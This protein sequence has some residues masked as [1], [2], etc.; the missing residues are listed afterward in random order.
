M[1]MT[2][3][4][5]LGV[6]GAAFAGPVQAANKRECSSAV[7]KDLQKNTQSV[8][9]VSVGT[10]KERTKSN[11]NREWTVINPPA[12]R[13][14]TTYELTVEFP[15]RT[16]VGEADGDW[17]FTYKPTQLVV[18]DPVEACIEGK[19]LIVKRPD[20]KDYKMNI[21]RVQ[22]NATATATASR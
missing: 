5:T 3:V 2:L 13:Q 6:L 14:H 4:I 11:G 8:G 20:G 19:K 18:N 10:A 22:R 21:I 15:D 1:K 12:T 16:Y 9:T 7:L 17:F